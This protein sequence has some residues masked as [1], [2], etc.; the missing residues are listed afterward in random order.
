MAAGSGNRLLAA[1]S[2]STES[3]LWSSHS[4][5]RAPLGAHSRCCES[6]RQLAMNKSGSCRAAKDELSCDQTYFLAAGVW[7][8]SRKES[9]CW[10]QYPCSSCVDM[11]IFCRRVSKSQS[12]SSDKP[13]IVFVGGTKGRRESRINR[14]LEGICVLYQKGMVQYML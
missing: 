6:Q 13:S 1:M 7:A 14:F 2:D 5:A 8:N 9:A 10:H 12:S 4:N 3:S 11:P